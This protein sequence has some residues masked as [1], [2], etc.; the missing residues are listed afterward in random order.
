MYLQYANNELGLYINIVHAFN[1]LRNQ[2]SIVDV[3]LRPLSLPNICKLMKFV[4]FEQQVYFFFYT[5]QVI[6]I[7]DSDKK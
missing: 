7:T 3:L 1:T 5:I 2:Q 6:K 4:S